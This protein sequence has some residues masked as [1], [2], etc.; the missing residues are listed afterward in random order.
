MRIVATMP[1]TPARHCGT[2]RIW[3]HSY[4]IRYTIRMKF[5]IRPIL[6][7]HTCIHTH[8]IMLNHV[9]YAETIKQS[10]ISDVKVWHGNTPTLRNVV[11]WCLMTVVCRY[12]STSGIAI[13]QGFDA[14]AMQSCKPLPCGIGSCQNRR[15]R[16]QIGREPG[17]GLRMFSAK[18]FP[19]WFPDDLYRGPSQ[20]CNDHSQLGAFCPWGPKPPLSGLKLGKKNPKS[21]LPICLTLTKYVNLLWIYV[22]VFSR[23][24]V[25]QILTCSYINVV[26]HHVIICGFTCTIFM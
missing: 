13:P 12:C 1:T 6:N 26:H 15:I 9:Y 24:E 17:P 2:N 5:Q 16:E 21:I 25:N 10:Q 23:T 8:A 19:L 22:L 7:A 3:S 18:F 14:P 4:S 20:V 11:H